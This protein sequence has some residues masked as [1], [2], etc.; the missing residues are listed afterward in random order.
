MTTNTTLDSNLIL[1]YKQMFGFNNININSNNCIFQ[2]GVTIVSNLFIS[3]NA[4][5]NDKTTILSSLNINQ[6]LN[7]NNNLNLNNLNIN[8]NLSTNNLTI[9]NLNV[10]NAYINN[11]LNSNNLLINNSSTILS[12]LNISGFTKIENVLNT[13]NLFSLNT[14]NIN[15]PIINIGSTNSQIIIN[16]TTNYI[17]SNDLKIS[18]KYI[19]LNNPALDIGNLCGYQ[20]LGISGNGYLI[21][22]NTADRFILKAPLKSTLEYILSTDINNNVIISGFSILNSDSYFNNLNS[23][24]LSSSNISANTLLCNNY[25]GNGNNTI[26]SII[27]NNNFVSNNISINSNLNISNNTIFNSNVTINNILLISGLSNLNNLNS[28]NLYNNN[29]LINLNTT[30]N[31]NLYSS[32]NI[33]INNNTSILSSLQG[34]NSNIFNNTV[35]IN[36][37]LNVSNNTIINGNTTILSNLNISGNCTFNNNINIGTNKNNNLTI[38][39]N[40]IVISSVSDYLNNST[41]INAGIPEWGIYRTGGILKIRLN[42]IPPVLTLY[43]NTTI[44]I[45]VGDNFIDPGLLAVDHFGNNIIPYI[46]Y[47]YNTS[48]TQLLSSYI[49]IS[50]PTILPI[51]NTSIPNIYSIWYEASDYVNLTTNIIRIVNIN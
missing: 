12:Q 4:I 14:I 2:G 22:N 34:N 1:K 41:A 46:K 5:I 27:V 29:L 17:A 30:L 13:T 42:D 39:S 20:I 36:S 28:N 48:N 49:Y 16:G 51:I 6:N 37:N 44:N 47:I 38:L 35:I 33:Y 25:I 10:N 8:N 32:N 45:L 9:N 3:T 11:N 18:D 19:I 7:I 21:T 31:S 15:A 23:E 40:N 43:G 50:Q 26:N 24:I